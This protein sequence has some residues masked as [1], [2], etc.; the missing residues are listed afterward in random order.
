MTNPQ[1]FE[2]WFADLNPQRGT[3]AGKIRPVVVV[4]TNLLNG[5]HPST[6]VCPI[7]TN[8]QS[9][10][11]LLRVYLGVGEAGLRQQ[12][13]ILVDQLRAIDNRRLLNCTGNLTQRSIDALKENLR[14]MLDL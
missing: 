3:E 11:T 9:A 4:Q 2:V 13:D 14:I 12:S 6:I 5:T 1:Q 10:A 8:V 7:T